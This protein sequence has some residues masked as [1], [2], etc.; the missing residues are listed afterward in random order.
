[1]FS[2]IL[3]PAGFDFQ[4]DDG[5][6]RSMKEELEN[7][8]RRMAN[9]LR[10][11][12]VEEHFVKRSKT[13]KL[14]RDGGDRH[15]VGRHRSHRQKTGNDSDVNDNDDDGDDIR[16]FIVDTDDLA[17]ELSRSSSGSDEDLDEA[18]ARKSGGKQDS[19]EKQKMEKK[20]RLE[21]RKKKYESERGSAS[22]EDEEEVVR[23]WAKRG[24]KPSARPANRPKLRV[25]VQV[26]QV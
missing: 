14:H 11:E 16:D 5:R 19:T 8:R 18:E 15:R 2:Q 21:E 26:V 3:R 1:M 22:S 17:S 10:Q 13:K 12:E 20:Q 24:A 9:K 4:K 25:N 23:V 6:I 7:R